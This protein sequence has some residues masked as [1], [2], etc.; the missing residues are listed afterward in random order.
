MIQLALEAQLN[1]CPQRPVLTLAQHPRGLVAGEPVWEAWR[2]W[3]ATGTVLGR[4]L[5]SAD[6]LQSKDRTPRVT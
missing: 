3:A 2:H 1:P 4:T 6:H 5:R